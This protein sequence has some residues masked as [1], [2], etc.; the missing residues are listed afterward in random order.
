MMLASDKWPRHPFLPVKN[1]E[2]VKP[3]DMPICAVM[4]AGFPS[5]VFDFNIFGPPGNTIQEIT[6]NAKRTDYDSLDDLL[7]AGWIVD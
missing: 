4:V 3:G 6:A 7:A 1:Y 5:T 2:G